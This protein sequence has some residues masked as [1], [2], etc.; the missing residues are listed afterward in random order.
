MQIRTAWK[1]DHVKAGRLEDCGW[2][3]IPVVVDTGPP[4]LGR[5]LV[6]R[7]VDHLDE[8]IDAVERITAIPGRI[9]FLRCND[10]RDAAGSGADRHANFSG[11]KS[12]DSS[13]PPTHLSSVSSIRLHGLSNGASQG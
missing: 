5:P 8:L 10:S 7:I 2:A 9:D 3:V 6:E 11:A 4:T 12:I 13:W 1:R